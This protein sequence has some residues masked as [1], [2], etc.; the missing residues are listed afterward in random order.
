MTK[1]QMELGFAVDYG[2]HGGVVS[3]TTMA[4]TFVAP[5]TAGAR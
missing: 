2:V 4:A 3:V 1:H 5:L